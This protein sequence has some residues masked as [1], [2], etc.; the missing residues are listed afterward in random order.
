MW[1]RE[2]LENVTK[3]VED[4]TS[5]TPR[6]LEAK[7]DV[8]LREDARSELCRDCGEGGT[9]TGEVQTIK[10]D[11]Q[12]EEGNQLVVEFA[13]LTCPNNHVWYQGEGQMRGIGGDDPILFEEHLQSRKRRE[14]YT[15]IGTPDPSIVAGMYNRVHPQGRKV[16][17]PEQRT[18]NGASFYR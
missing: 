9:A 15:T 18:R 17:S 12:D 6:E 14:I 10:Q 4:G 16:N 3:E 5:Y 11:A 7:A 13:E 1:R 8:W 2:E